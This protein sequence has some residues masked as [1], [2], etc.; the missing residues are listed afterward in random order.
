MILEAL[1][2]AVVDVGLSP[3]AFGALTVSE[4]Q[5]IVERYEASWTRDYRTTW[6][7][8]RTLVYAALAPHLKE[9]VTLREVMPFCSSLTCLQILEMA[10]ALPAG[11][12][13]SMRM[14]SCPKSF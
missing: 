8:T 9:G 4:W 13:S 3:E 12:P 14:S 6:E 7:Q 10:S 2:C 5:A 1:A 11:S